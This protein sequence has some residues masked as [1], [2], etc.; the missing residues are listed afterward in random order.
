MDSYLA[1]SFEKGNVQVFVGSGL[2]ALYP[3]SHKLRKRLLKDP[4][5][6]EGDL[7][8]LS[9]VLGS[10][11]S[12]PL[13]DAAEFY[14]IYQGSHALV[15]FIR[16]VYGASKRPVEVHELL[17]KLPNVR[18]IY[19]TNFDCLIE[20]ALGRPKQP[21]RVITRAADISEVPRELR[22]VFKPHGCAR[23]S[24]SRSDFVI[25]RNDYLNYSHRHTLE[26]L[27]TLYDLST[28][29]FLFLGYGLR[30][31]NMR[32][33]VTEASRYGNVRSYAVLE[34]ASG[35]E[36]RYWHNLGVTLIESDATRFVRKI[37]KS[38]PPYEF[39]WD[40]KVD[41]RVE[42]KE[43]IA[44]KALLAVK[45]E[46]KKGKPFNI[47]IDAGSST[48]FFARALTREVKE[49]NLS[50]ENVHIITNSPPAMDEL[51]PAVR[52]SGGRDAPTIIGGHLR[53]GTRAYTPDAAS[54]RDQLSRVKESVARTLV[55][56]GATAI[57][58]R[59][60]E[61]RTKEEVAIK[62]SFVEAASKIYV[63]TDHSKIRGLRGGHR[64]AKWDKKRMTI[65]TDRPREL[66]EMKKHCKN[67]R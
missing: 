19:T 10:V 46:L 40:E 41:A 31:L 52:Q 13:E 64:F 29:V 18:W 9:E 26:R 43:E 16:N 33:I 50:L 51:T 4:I 8:K 58:K 25:S 27:K 35:P 67:V 42:E 12:V 24:M 59:G 39:E 14:E 22:V 45:K 23:R 32:H 56:I 66:K 44:N 47:I 37:L 20:D 5:Y 3:N 49:K 6:V 21:P 62:R 61:T 1:D 11:D 38:F 30:D 7:T 54:A 28:Q 15:R 34:K 48:L 53:F 36:S 17:W 2:S 55:F 60:L 57:T 63:L 65:I